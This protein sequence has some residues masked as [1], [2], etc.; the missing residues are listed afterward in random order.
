M[1][2]SPISRHQ[3]SALSQPSETIP[4]LITPS[5]MAFSPGALPRATVFRPVRGAAPEGG[6][7]PLR[8]PAPKGRHRI[9]RGSAPGSSARGVAT[10]VGQ[11]HAAAFALDQAQEQLAR[12]G[13]VLVEPGQ[14][15]LARR[16]LRP[17]LE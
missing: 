15:L 1:A 9:A 4:P 2:S 10:G 12:P 11:L 6:A 8:E 14:E 16:P 17:R 5:F 7:R 13:Q 3:A